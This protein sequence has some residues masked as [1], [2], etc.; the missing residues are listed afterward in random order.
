MAE[1]TTTSG[2][3]IEKT[4]ARMY[5]EKLNRHRLF[6]TSSDAEEYLKDWL[7]FLPSDCNPHRYRY[8]TAEVRELITPDNV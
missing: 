4:F 8:Y 3:L 2:F 5:H 6:D 1:D 7:S